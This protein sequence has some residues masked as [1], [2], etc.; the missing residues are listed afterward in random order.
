MTARASCLLLLFSSFLFA[1]PGDEEFRQ[2][3]ETGQAFYHHGKHD[4]AINEF[5]EAVRLNPSSSLA[6][7]WLGRALGRKAEK[8]N[9]LRAVFLVGDVRRKFER[10]VEL[11]PNNVEARSDLLQFYLDAP[12]M[13]GGGLEKAR[14]QAEA[15]ERL[16][17]AEGHSAWARIAEKEKRYDVAEREYRAATEADP[18][19]P[20]YGRDLDEF[21]KKHQGQGSKPKVQAPRS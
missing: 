15:I 21:L 16:N 12:G 7:L 6:H 18:K 10:A 4:R 2:H 1:L 8:S 13:F 11:D 5:R 20:G 9:P 3:L 14:K 19:H 17:R